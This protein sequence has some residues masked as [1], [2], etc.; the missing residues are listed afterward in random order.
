MYAV[1]AYPGW[2]TYKQ[3]DGSVIEIMRHGDEWG[4]WTTDRQGRVVR[5]ENDGFFRVVPGVTSKMMASRAA[6]SREEHRRSTKAAPGSEDYVALGQKHFLVI[7]VE[8]SDLSYKIPNPKQSI[9]DLLNKEGYNANGALGSARD[10]YYDN[11]HEKFEPVFDVYGPVKL[12]KTKKYYGENIDDNDAHPAEMI[13]DACSLLSSEIDFSQYD[14][15]NDGFVDLVYVYYAGFGE[16][17]SADSDSVWPHQWD[18]RSAG[19]NLFYNGKQVA[20][21]ACSNELVGSGNEKGKLTGIGTVSHEFGHAMGL[22]DFYDTDYDKNGRSA[23]LYDYSLMSSGSHNGNGRIPPYLN[24]LERILL[25]WLD[26][27]ALVDISKSGIYSL[28]SVHNDIA[29]KIPSD[30]DNEYFILECRKSDSWDTKLPAKTYGMV[31]YHVDMSSNSVT[32][33]GKSYKASVLW[34]KW[35][36][37]NAL[38]ASGDHPCFYVVPSAAQDDLKYGY[39]YNN[40][41][42]NYDASFA[43]RIPFPGSSNITE[44]TPV[45]W[46]GAESE[47][48]IKEIA[49]DG[50]QVTFKASTASATLDYPV[51]NNPKAGV[52]SVGEKFP[53]T[54]VE[55]D[56]RPSQSVEWSFDGNAVPA[57]SVTLTAGKHTVDAKVTCVDG[58]VCYVTLEITVK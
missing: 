20:R 23:A 19:I 57:G 39:Y 37:T 30:V 27:S 49:F 38:N 44:Y 24:V 55:S 4:H 15:D 17:D 47:I 41:R 33:D 11:S 32:L 14:L 54:L 46:S 9:S 5:L 36:E 29:Y 7:L 2:I 56:F 45:S 16:A 3:P 13:R 18:L 12:S 42:W 6:T 26:E 25:G 50:N 31:A 21:Y 8:F 22:P 52:Y 58:K 10:Y 34:S 51:I 1:P 35:R 53:L 43:P 48:S 28:P 40:D